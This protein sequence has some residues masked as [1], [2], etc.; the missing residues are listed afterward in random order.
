M[1]RELARLRRQIE[2]ETFQ[3]HRPEEVSDDVHADN[4]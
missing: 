3:R 1:P 2:L 4:R